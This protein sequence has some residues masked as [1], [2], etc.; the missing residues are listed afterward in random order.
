MS[1]SWEGAAPQAT[2]FLDCCESC[3][4]DASLQESRKAHLGICRLYVHLSVLNILADD[5]RTRR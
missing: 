4:H 1:G 2:V 3:G 5:L